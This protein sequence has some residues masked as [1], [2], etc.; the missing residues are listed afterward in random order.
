MYLKCDLLFL[1]ITYVFGS[2]G[3]SWRWVSRF[4]ICWLGVRGL[5]IIWLGVRLR[6]DDGDQCCENKELQF[7]LRRTKLKLLSLN[8][9]RSL[10]LLLSLCQDLGLVGFESSLPSCWCFESWNGAVLSV[11][12]STSL[13]TSGR[14]EIE[15][16]Q[17]LLKYILN[18][19]AQIQGLP[20]IQW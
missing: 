6:S 1:N 5:G 15:F 18:K 13:Y 17:G 16:G 12:N 20:A 9:C 10:Y 2:L 7:K 8:Y 19:L 11:H 4:G 3:V 14:K